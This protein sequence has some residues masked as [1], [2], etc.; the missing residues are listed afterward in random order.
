MTAP[1]M[2]AAALG[3]G[4]RAVSMVVGTTSGAGSGG[5]ARE[6]RAQADRQERRDEGE[7]ESSHVSGIGPKAR[8][9]ERVT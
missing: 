9:H 2:K 7:A 3:A 1:G 5:G 4:S 8:G 6:E